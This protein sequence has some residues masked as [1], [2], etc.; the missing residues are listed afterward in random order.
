MV[1]DITI[2]LQGGLEGGIFD[3]AAFL[4]VPTSIIYN[5]AG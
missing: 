5:K 1:Q 4:F 2:T 3:V